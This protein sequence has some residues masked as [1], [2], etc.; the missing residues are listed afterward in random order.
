MVGLA[1]NDLSLAQVHYGMLALGDSSY[2][3]FCGFGR[4]LDARLQQLGAQPMFERIEVDRNKAEAIERW[5]QNLV[6]IVGTSDL[7]DWS[8]P[9]FD[10]WTLV[11]R[12]V[13]NPGSA[14]APVF[15]L[16]LTPAGGALPA[17][18]SGDLAQIVT[19]DDP[20]HPRE[21]S[22]ASIPEDGR[23]QLLVRLHRRPDGTEGMAS[24]WL[25][26]RLA[27]GGALKMRVRA[28]RRFRLEEN[29]DRPLILIGNG[30]G[31]AGLCSHLK[32]R[33]RGIEA[34][35]WLIFGERNARCDF[36]YQNEIEAWR[37]AGVL[38]RVDLA[39][40]RDGNDIRYVQ[41]CLAA[42]GNEVHEWI[43]RGA[44]IYVC[45]SLSTMA[46]GVD[47]ALADLLGREQL[48]ELAASGRYR[49]DVY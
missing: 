49:R 10:D 28:H 40:S 26:S 41:D 37:T 32:A 38:Q 8:G 31:I 9:A 39:F 24:G 29:R 23:V 20:E 11:E 2:V 36:H 7:P 48:D 17:W 21:Y 22:I 6:H 42:A 34:T 5:K 12:R 4:M 44:A 1:G 30:T 47:D 25:G 3:H 45:G 19:P 15:H 16:E 33:I 27:V 18:E 43:Q 13:L 14:G 46:A 35:N